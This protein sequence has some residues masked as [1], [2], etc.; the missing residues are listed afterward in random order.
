[1]VQVPAAQRHNLRRIGVVRE[2][3]RDEIGFSGR[4][5][6]VDVNRHG[7]ELVLCASECFQQRNDELGEF[8]STPD[9]DAM[10][11]DGIFV[12]DRLQ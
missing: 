8:T 7:G 12:I 3:V 9:E 6:T 5:L 1:L 4:T 11:V 10:V 2:V